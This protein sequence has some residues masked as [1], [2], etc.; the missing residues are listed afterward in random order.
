MKLISENEWHQISGAAISYM[1][2]SVHVDT[3]GIPSRC[4]GEIEGF[5]NS[6]LSVYENPNFTATMLM[7][8]MGPH[9]DIMMASGCDAYLETYDQRLQALGRLYA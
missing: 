9:I 1:G 2:Q 3:T 7:N 8:A 4:V 6:M 5:A